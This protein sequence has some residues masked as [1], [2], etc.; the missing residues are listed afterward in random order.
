MTFNGRSKCFQKALNTQIPYTYIPQINRFPIGILKRKGVQLEPGTIESGGIGH[1]VIVWDGNSSIP[2]S[3]Y[4]EHI[5][6]S[7]ACATGLEI[8]VDVLD[9]FGHGL[10]SVP[11]IANPEFMKRMDRARPKPL[12]PYESN[13]EVEGIES[14][15]DAEAQCRRLNA[16]QRK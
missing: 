2:P 7:M 10:S 12:R 6:L 8:E 11:L 9:A 5:S 3:L 14:D 13:S 16:A 15:F 4:R 1:R